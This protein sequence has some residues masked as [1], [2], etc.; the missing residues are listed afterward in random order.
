MRGF[1]VYLLC[2]YLID[3][4]DKEFSFRFSRTLFLQGDSFYLKWI[5]SQMEEIFF[6]ELE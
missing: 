1:D 3:G 2:K 6:S 4:T 5:K